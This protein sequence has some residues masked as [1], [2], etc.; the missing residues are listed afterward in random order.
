MSWSYSKKFLSK[1]EAIEAVSKAQENGEF[2]DL[3]GLFLI[4]AIEQQDEGKGISV[5]TNG[6]F[7]RR[8][9]GSHKVTECHIMVKTV[10]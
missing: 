6:H 9:E 5:A 2:P 8:R 7:Y 4:P 10:E 3:V 1:S